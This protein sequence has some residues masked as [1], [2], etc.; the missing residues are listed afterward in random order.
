MA[1]SVN[2]DYLLG[3]MQNGILQAVLYKS[4]YFLTK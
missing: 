3:V 2:G 4:I 1:H